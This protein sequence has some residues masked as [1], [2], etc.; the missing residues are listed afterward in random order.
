MKTKKQITREAK[1]LFRFCF[2]DGWMNDDR[3]RLVVARAVE[4]KHRGYLGVLGQFRRL[5]KIER[6]RHTAHVESAVPLSSDLK[7]EVQTGLERRYGPR[8]D[9]SFALRP[10]LIG[11]MRVKVGSDVYDGSLRFGLETLEQRF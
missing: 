5:V 10:E 7:T 3:V 4:E 9:I 8:I 6:E 2:V 1:Q 11:G